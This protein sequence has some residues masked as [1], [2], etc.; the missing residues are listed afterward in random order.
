M[1]A[2][3]PN[4]M[5]PFASTPR[6]GGPPG[7]VEAPRGRGACVVL[8][9]LWRGLRGGVRGGAVKLP[10]YA[11]AVRACRLEPLPPQ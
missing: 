9:N 11:A 2:H 7:Q 5:L 4:A 6:P 8:Y 10:A 1:C 3:T